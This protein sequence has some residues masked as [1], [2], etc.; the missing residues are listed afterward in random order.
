MGEPVVSRQVWGVV[1]TAAIS[2]AIALLLAVGNSRTVGV[3][4]GSTP[5]PLPV[6]GLGTRV[7]ALET[8]LAALGGGGA[9]L[10]TPVAAASPVA[11]AATPAA[12]ASV[13]YGN[14]REF[15]GPGE[16]GEL[17]VVASGPVGGYSIPVVVRN[18]TDRT[19]A[20][21]EVGGEV[22]DGAG[23]LV[24]AGSSQPFLPTIVPPGELAIGSV[25]FGGTELPAGASATFDVGASDDLGLYSTNG[26]IS[27][28]LVEFAA[29]PD[30][31]VGS[32]RNPSGTPIV[33]NV[34]LRVA[35]FGEDGM[36]LAEEPAIAARTDLAP[37]E[38]TAFDAFSS[39]LVPPCGRFLITG[40]GNS[41]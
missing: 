18:N 5:T 20:R 13:V 39:G 29:R 30:V 16:P 25:L 21:V 32:F 4:Q 34:Y 2:S 17:S 38:T 1:T 41:A 14:A 7:A 27:V 12:G 40:H 11:P 23:N 22:R 19:L 33:G 35:C 31:I 8:Q 24:A 6:E 15:L 28:E 3:G 36:L 10:A 37:G 9:P 26:P